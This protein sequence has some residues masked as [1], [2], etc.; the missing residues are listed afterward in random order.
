MAIEDHDYGELFTYI[1]KERA[2]Q[3]VFQPIISLHS[4]QIYGYEALSRG[5]A[6]TVLQ[7]PEMLFDYAL[8]NGQL[9]ELENL[10]RA[11]AL[12]CA[13]ELKAQ[14]KLFLNVNPNIMND[15]KFKQGFTKEYLS[16]FKMDADSIVFEITEREAINNLKDF[17]NTIDHY[18]NQFYQIAVDDVGAGYSGLNV[19]TDVHPHYMK[20]DMKLIRDI[21]RD[22]T[23][24][25]LVSSLSEFA[26]YSQ[27]NIIAEGIE[28]RDEL[29]TLIDIG[30]H[31]G[32]GY[33][34]QKPAAQLY[35]VR[36]E[37]K[38]TIK[39]EISRKN[40]VSRN[41]LTDTSIEQIATPLNTISSQMPISKVSTLM[42]A[43]DLLPGF[44]I[45]DGNKLIGVITRNKLHLKF[46]GPYGYSLYNKKPV[47]TIMS[48]IYMKVDA[49]TPIDVVA[50]IAMKRDPLHLYDFITVTKDEQYF[51]VVTVKDL[52]EKSMQLEIDYAKHLN[53]LSELPGNL[54]IEQQLQTCIDA[55]SDMTVLYFDIDNFKPY[56]D[57]YGFE[58][59]DKV[60]MHFA[61]I[62]ESSCP[63]DGFVG[64]IGGDDFLLITGTAKSKQL[65]EKIIQQFDKSVEQFYHAQDF[66]K[67]HIISK[68]RHGIEES[69]PLLTISIAGVSN[70]NTQTIYELSE[71]ASQLKKQCKQIPGS[72]Y[73]LQE[74]SA[75]V[76]I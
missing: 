28:T 38:T 66:L 7:N 58:K 69:F 52:L 10:C 35:P 64:H 22:R 76:T 74:P 2:I 40:R 30:V 6:N 4:G 75:I 41:R 29:R 27:I 46:S 49:E 5:P 55:D 65:C 53:P 45:Q 39:A 16:K 47:S 72:T 63:P 9:W 71:L 32:Q 68:N 13:Y 43:N 59:G 44:C 56:N 70:K 20:L 31:F 17:I 21:D 73:I 12:K 57:V 18:K 33:Y 8:K 37:V 19:L 1:L 25:L 36:E 11:N 67:G 14:G 26:N 51:G 3:T 48:R 24:Q 62:I 15:S 61:E 54:M 23:K 60:I 50:K 42:E 34:I